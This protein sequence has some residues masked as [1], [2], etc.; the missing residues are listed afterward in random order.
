M[1]GLYDTDIRLDSSWQL[2]PAAN[3]D[4]PLVSGLDCLFQDIQLEALTQEGELFYDE[5]WGWSL[6]DF[7]QSQDDD[8][9]RLE[10]QQR[11]KD[12]LKNRSE[13]DTETIETELAFDSDM[14]SVKVSFKFVNDSQTY[15]LNLEL[16]RVKVEVILV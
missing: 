10:I 2:T 1:A 6:L 14:I 4:T 5:T 11:V 8:I 16:D 7:I 9:V 3:G 15:Q 13:I 12:K